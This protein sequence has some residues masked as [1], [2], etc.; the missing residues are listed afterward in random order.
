MASDW[1]D[2]LTGLPRQTNRILNRID[3]GDLEVRIDVRDLNELMNRVDYLANRVIYGILIAALLL[4]TAFLIPR[5]DFSWTW[6]LLTW[7][8]VL[9]FVVLLFLGLQLLWSIL[10][11]GRRRR[12]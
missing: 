9:G 1:N 2:L 11:S 5:L 6:N 12:K 7:I 8:V 3:R 4:A 10:R